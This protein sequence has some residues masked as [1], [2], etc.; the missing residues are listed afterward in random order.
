MNKAKIKLIIAALVF[1]LLVGGG[2]YFVKDRGLGTTAEYEKQFDFV[3]PTEAVYAEENEP[4]DDLYV[5]PTE[6]WIKHSPNSNARV[7]SAFCDENFQGRYVI[8]DVEN[9]WEENRGKE[10]IV[11]CV[12]R[13]EF[14]DFFLENANITTSEDFDVFGEAEMAP[15][16]TLSCITRKEGTVNVDE[17]LL[18]NRQDT[19]VFYNLEKDYGDGEDIANPDVDGSERYL[20]GIDV[21]I[22]DTAEYRQHFKDNN[23]DI[24]FSDAEIVRLIESKDL[25]HTYSDGAVF[26]AIVD[27]TVSCNRNDGMYK[28]LAWIPEAG[29]QNRV[30]FMITCYFD[31]MAMEGEPIINH[32]NWMTSLGVYGYEPL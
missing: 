27:A 16:L 25:L 7:Y 19:V 2:V 12:D 1:A 15:L 3:Y 20:S 5:Q 11:K 13:E 10:Y 17:P 31:I 23:L 14:E 26:V 8:L 21:T 32:L 29:H 9:D 30:R 28:D 18:G 22:G 24:V 6:V 4:V